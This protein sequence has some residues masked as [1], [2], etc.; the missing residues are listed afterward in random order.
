LTINLQFKKK[1]FPALL[2][3]TSDGEKLRR[4]FF[5]AEYRLNYLTG[6]YK[7]PYVAIINGI[8]MGGVSK[9]I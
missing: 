8:T 4:E 7:L 9:S 1:T 2:A 5:R 6:I 3:K